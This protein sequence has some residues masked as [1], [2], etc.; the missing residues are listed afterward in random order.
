MTFVT[1]GKVLLPPEL[2]EEQRTWRER[3]PELLRRRANLLLT[4]ARDGSRPRVPPPSSPPPL[5][6]KGASGRGRPISRIEIAGQRQS[7]SPLKIAS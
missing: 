3:A 5:G 7:G 6:T 1:V 4:I 2:A